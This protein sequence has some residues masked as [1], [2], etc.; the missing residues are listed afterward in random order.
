MIENLVPWPNGAR[1]AVALT[2]DI[3]SESPLHLEYRD[4]VPDL[5]ATTSWMR[6][7]KIAVPRI[8]LL[9]EFILMFPRV[10]QPPRHSKPLFLSDSKSCSRLAR[11]IVADDHVRQG[12]ATNRAISRLAAVATRSKKRAP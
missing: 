9:G 5:V 10:N 11:R 3:D 12:S 8:Q 1:C 4:H 6:Y 2:F 7:D